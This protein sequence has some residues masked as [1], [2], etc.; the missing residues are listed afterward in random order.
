[1]GTD[2]LEEFTAA[3]ALCLPVIDGVDGIYL[4]TAD[5]SVSDALVLKNDDLTA[6]NELE[7][8]KTAS[9]NEFEID[10][11]GDYDLLEISK[12]ESWL[13]VSIKNKKAIVKVAAN[14]ETSAP[15]RQGDVVVTDGYNTFTVTIKQAANS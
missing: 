10:Y 7:V 12:E 1:M 2:P 11:N 6:D 3:Q 5:E 9:T 4:L 15:A 14:S 13:T 8:A